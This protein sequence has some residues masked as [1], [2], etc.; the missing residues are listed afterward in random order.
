MEYFACGAPT[1]FKTGMLGTSFLHPSHV[2]PLSTP[3][4]GHF[5][6]M[7]IWAPHQ[8]MQ[9]MHR[10]FRA[11]HSTPGHSW[12]LYRLTRQQEAFP[13]MII[14]ALLPL[15]WLCMHIFPIGLITAHLSSLRRNGLPCCG[16]VALLVMFT[17]STCLCYPASSELQSVHC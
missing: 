17:I 7:A 15:P 1:V 14:Q 5:T 10:F 16:S 11:G 6:M 12:L 3:E 8:C 4:S 13:G 2:R 9:G